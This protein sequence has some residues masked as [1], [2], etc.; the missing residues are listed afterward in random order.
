LRAYDSIVPTQAIGQLTTSSQAQ[1][2]GPLVAALPFDQP[3]VVPQAIFDAVL[4]HSVYGQDSTP[5][6]AGPD[7][8]P[9]EAERAAGALAVF[10]AGGNVRAWLL[11]T[12]NDIVGDDI[13]QA[14]GMTRGRHAGRVAATLTDDDG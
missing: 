1:A 9:L 5:P 10:R 6:P 2:A 8:S 4:W 3:D 14:V 11:R 12:T 7:A 13:A